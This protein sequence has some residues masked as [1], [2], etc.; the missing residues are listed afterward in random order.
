MLLAHKLLPDF[1][2]YSKLELRTFED[3]TRR[4]Y[5]WRKAWF[6]ARSPTMLALVEQL[7]SYL[8]GGC[9]S[10]PMVYVNESC[11]ECERVRAACERLGAVAAVRG[12]EVLP[13][14]QQ[15]PAPP[16]YLVTAPFEGELFDAAH[17]AKY[18]TTTATTLMPH[19]KTKSNADEIVGN[20]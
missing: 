8:G 9:S 10:T 11:L 16:S 14:T 1:P 20:S 7:R 6:A 18:R 19:Q 3:Y 5:R 17:K 12:P 15:Q 4:C 13:L 2:F